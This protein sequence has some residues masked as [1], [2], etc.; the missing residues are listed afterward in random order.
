MYFTVSIL[1]SSAEASKVTKETFTK[2]MAEWIGKQNSEKIESERT[3]TGISEKL[4]EEIKQIL[5]FSNID[6]V[7]DSGERSFWADGEADLAYLNEYIVNKKVKVKAELM[8]KRSGNSL[9][10]YIEFDENTW[11]YFTYKNNMMQTL[12]SNKEYNQI[13]QALKAEDRK[14]KGEAFTFIMSPGK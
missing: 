13:V 9:D 8:R 7:W 1:N 12:S 4:P 3:G 5:L 14:Q 10:M 2:R 11:V 6:F